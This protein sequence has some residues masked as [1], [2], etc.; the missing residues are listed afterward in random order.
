VGAGRRHHDQRISD[1]VASAEIAAV[2]MRDKGL[3][4]DSDAVTRTDFVRRVTLQ[5]N[6]MFRKG[7]AEKIGRG[8]A[9]R[10]KLAGA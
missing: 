9:M 6:D 2:A 10:W 4:P 1:S 8:R 3:D 7:K 5:L